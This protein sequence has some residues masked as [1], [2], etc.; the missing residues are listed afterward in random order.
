MG[1]HSIGIVAIA[2]VLSCVAPDARTADARTAD[3]RAPGVSSQMAS[4]QGEDRMERLAALAQKEGELTIYHVYPNLPVVL[5]AFSA[6]YG[7]KVKPWRSSSEG[8][9]QRFTN[10]AHGNRFEVDV[11]QNNAPENEAA[12]REK[13][14]QEVRSPL[15]KDIMPAASPAHREWVG[16]TIDVFVAAY[17]TGKVATAELPASYPDLLDPKWKGRLGIEVDDQAWFNTLAAALGEKETYKLFADIVARNGMSVRKGHSLLTNLVASGEVPLG[18]TVYG[19]I[20]E[21]L[22]SK[23]APIEVLPIPPVIAQF[24][25]IAVAKRAPHPHAALLFED[26]ML[27]EG[28]R[29]LAQQGWVPTSVNIDTPI[30]NVPLRFIDPEQALDQQDR[31]TRTYE[32]VVTKSRATPAK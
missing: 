17:N 8:V 21:Q 29:L 20:P 27:G 4:Y 23:G 2:L 14:L 26:F 24:S 31:W 5:N 16:I 11:V 12:H 13:L 15:L 1:R 19:W 7:I 32:E 22:K 9:L 30:K 25:T 10:E 3:A 28:Q 6:K 18:L